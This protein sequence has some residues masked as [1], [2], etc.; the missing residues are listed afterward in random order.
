MNN[1]ISKNKL[2]V[3]SRTIE[4]DPSTF[5]SAKVVVLAAN[6]YNAFSQFRLAADMPKHLTCE[7]IGEPSNPCIRYIASGGTRFYVT[8]YEVPVNE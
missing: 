6:P 2:Y 4:I 7:D 5:E 1:P 3:I 8:P